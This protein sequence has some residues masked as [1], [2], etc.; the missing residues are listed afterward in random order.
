LFVLLALLGSGVGPLPAQFSLT[1]TNYTQNFNSLGTNATSAWSN[2]VTLPG[3]FA[4][5]QLVTNPTAILNQNGSTAGSG[6]W[7]NFSSSSTNTD[8]S[9]GWIV[10]NSTASELGSMASFGFGLSNSTG[11]R[12]GSFSLGYVG[13]EWR[14]YSN[15]TA[16][17]SFQYKLGGTF[18][19]DP[20]NA[21]SGGGWTDVPALSFVLPVTNANTAV[22]GLVAP[23]FT[24]I[25]NTV[26]G[27]TW[28][29]NQVLWLRWRQENLPSVDPQ[30]AVDDVVFTASASV[31][32]GNYWSAVPGG[33]GTGTW[34]AGGTNWATD[35]GG[36]GVGR[37]QG[38]G[39]LIFADNA[40]T[41]TVSGGVGVTQGMIFQATGYRVQGDPITLAGA[42]VGSNS[43]RVEAGVVTVMA[44]ALAGSNGLAKAGTG[45]LVLPAANSFSGG[46]EITDGTLEIASDSALGNAAN[47]LVNHGALKTTAN[48]SLAASR[49][50]SGSGTYDIGHGTTL[51]LLGNVNHSG[52][53]LADSTGV[54]V[55]VSNTLSPG[56]TLAIANGSGTRNLG[57]ITFNAARTL[58]AGAPVNATGLSA[59]GLTA[60]MARVNADLVF[61]TTGAKTV[62]VPAGGTLAINGAL[63]NSATSVNPLAKTGGGTLILSGPNNMGALSVGLSAALPTEG[64]IVILDNS[65]V[66]SQPRAIQ[67]NYGNLVATRNLVFTN[68]LSIGGRANG[69]AVLSGADMEFRGQSAFFKAAG[70][71]GELRLNVENTTTFSGG[72]GPA[73]G[74]GTAT[75]V[76]LGGSGRIILDGVGA[77]FLDQ[78]TLTDTV[79]LTMKG[80]LGSSL[81]VGRSALLSV[82]GTNAIVGGD[83]HFEYGGKYRLNT[84][85]PTLT[86]DGVSVSFG[87]FRVD[88][89]VGLNSDTPLGVYVLFNGRVNVFSGTLF[90]QGLLNAANVGGGKLAYFTTA[91]LELNVVQAIPEI[92]VLNSDGV[93]TNALPYFAAFVNTPASARWFTVLGTNL[94]APIAVVASAGFQVSTD[95]ATWGAATALAPSNNN[96]S[97]KV[98]IRMVVSPVAGS[99]SG[100]VTLSSDRATNKTLAVSGTVWSA[101]AA[102]AAFHLLS[103]SEA[104]LTADLDHDGF[105]NGREFAFG[106][107]PRI[108][109]RTLF[110]TTLS[111]G[112]L[113]SSWKGPAEGVIYVVLTTTNLATTPWAAPTP[114]I[115]I[116]TTVE[117][118]MSFTN[119]VT[120]TR[121]FGVRAMFD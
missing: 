100:T 61:T 45:R 82:E 44:S 42:T 96:V 27:L 83:L 58:E 30:M 53:T 54:G 11:L 6:T 33:G 98:Y 39:T 85:Q 121:F 97:A 80:S 57:F 7:A 87:G 24:A 111:N 32:S 81:T 70:T 16:K 105:D 68:G 86:V 20:V 78:V 56:G 29:T 37:T 23:N 72:F 84:N 48:L 102:W 90:N 3:W 10:G 88:D 64:G 40:G 41:V 73:T 51:T 55:V 50:V 25:S 15:S 34:A 17:L 108:W 74:G 31:V 60:G 67:H 19:N 119:A 95:N 107:H 110:T 21:V 9:L 26:A 66:G 4:S 75:G 5:A 1:T 49:D 109:N 69:V 93:P 77:S 2:N 91:N 18:N 62:H 71:T 28:L 118:I 101:Y 116:D 46:V 59:P 113:R 94:T 112:V 89:I 47:D 106:T 115:P 38:E 43:I 65:V 52:T 22:N 8:R 117:G 36:A 99:V 35:S 120:G 114:A 76:T 104:L 12:L 63:T 92:R 103:G 14:G 79:E 13:R